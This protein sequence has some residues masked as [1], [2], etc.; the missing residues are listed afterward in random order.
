MVH[1]TDLPAIRFF[2]VVSTSAPSGVTKPKPVTTTRRID[3]PFV[4]PCPPREAAS[5]RWTR[6]HKKGFPAT[7]RERSGPGSRKRVGG[8]AAASGYAGQSHVSP[9][10][11]RYRRSH[12]CRWRSFPPHR[13]G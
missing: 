9:C 11:L 12:P 4:G 3:I 10:S 1:A 5:T 6:V 8:V 7:A 2:Q 13:Q